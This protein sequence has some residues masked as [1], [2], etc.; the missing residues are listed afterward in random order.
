MP[1]AAVL[2]EEHVHPVAL[3]HAASARRCCARRRRRSAPSCPANTASALC[4][5]SSICRFSAGRRASTR[6][7]NSAVSS[8]SRSGERDVLDDDRLGVLLQPRLLAARQVPAG[9]DDDRQVAAALGPCLICSSSSKPVVVGQPG[10]AP[11]SRT[12][13]SSSAVER[14]LAVPTATI[15]TSSPADQ[16]DDAR[17]ARRR[18]PRR[19]AGA[20]RARSTNARRSRRA[21]RSS[22]SRPT[23]F[24]R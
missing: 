7:R 11:C 14:L 5:C 19:P 8:S 10:R 2:G 21:P 1:V 18:R 12:R 23:G 6:C 24:S 4:S 13:S 17:R 22:A 9:V 3:E 16:L 15:S 20:S